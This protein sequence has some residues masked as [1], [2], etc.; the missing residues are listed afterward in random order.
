MTYDSAFQHASFSGTRTA[1]TCQLLM[2]VTDAWSTGPSQIP[3]PC[4]QANSAPDRLTPCSVTVLPVASTSLLPDTCSCGA[5]PPP[6]VPP[7][8]TVTETD[9]EAA[10]VP[11]ASNASA[12]SE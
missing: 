5:G 1:V 8:P 7:P 6:P 11:A 12:V 3:L 4:T 9:V 10:V 2:A